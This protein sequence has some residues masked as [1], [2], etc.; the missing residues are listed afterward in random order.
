[1]A[2]PSYTLAPEAKIGD[3]TREIAQ[4]IAYAADKV[5]GPIRVTGHSAGGQLATRM[6]CENSPLEGALQKR[7]VKTLSISGL[8]DL[9]NL[10][11]TKLNDA[12]K[13]TGSEA[14]LE[15]PCL[16]LPIKSADVTCWVGADERP[17]FIRQSQLLRDVWEKQGT[18]IDTVIEQG[19][20]HLTIID[21]L[22]SPSSRLTR[23]LLGT[24]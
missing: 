11:K 2:I 17:E 20:H 9:R 21:G 6:I 3:M 23:T 22:S 19:K 16:S 4:A 10:L 5:A 7:I 1:V 15:S 24:P 8:H 18:K 13:L 12:L 14:T